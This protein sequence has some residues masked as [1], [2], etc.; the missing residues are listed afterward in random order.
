MAKEKSEPPSRFD[1]WLDVCCSRLVHAK[2]GVTLLSVFARSRGV[3]WWGK[4]GPREH[5]RAP[6]APSGVAMV[7]VHLARDIGARA[8]DLF[9]RISAR[10]SSQCTSFKL[11]DPKLHLSLHTLSSD[12]P[13]DNASFQPHPCGHFSNISNH[14]ICE[15]YCNQ[16]PK[17]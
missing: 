1:C 10:L 17:L 9:A 16:K 7:T 8:F 13:Q 11:I 12:T 15:R 14:Q 5:T 6:P 3:R 4:C 2:L